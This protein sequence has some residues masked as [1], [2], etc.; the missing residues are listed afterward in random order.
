M[1]SRPILRIGIVVVGALLVPAIRD[2]GLT[3]I[4]TLDPETPGIAFG[5]ICTA[6][7]IVWTSLFLAA[8]VR[9]FGT[10][11]PTHTLLFTLVALIATRIDHLMTEP[12]QFIQINEAIATFA[13]CLLVFISHLLWVRRKTKQ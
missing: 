6:L 4:P 8:Y 7:L 3:L 1:N 10:M 2:V 9:L 13:A 5:S 12:A 11:P